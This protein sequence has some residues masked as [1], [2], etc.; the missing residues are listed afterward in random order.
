MRTRSAVDL[1]EQYFRALMLVASRYWTDGFGLRERQDGSTSSKRRLET[2]LLVMA[3]RRRRSN[4]V[5]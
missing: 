5:R 1:E 4:G 2:R 3:V